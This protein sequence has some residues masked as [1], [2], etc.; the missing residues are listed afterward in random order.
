MPELNRRRFLQAASAAGLAPLIPALPVQAATVSRSASTAQMLWASIY[1]R[2]GTAQNAVGVAQS[3]GVQG[4]AAQGVYARAIQSG[5][6]AAHGATRIGRLAS[7]RSVPGRI[8][9]PRQAPNP[10][11]MRLDLERLIRTDDDDVR[12]P[13]EVDDID[14]RPPKTP[15]ETSQ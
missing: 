2:A 1:A 6:M 3:L 5:A 13:V 11:S 4:A 9:S 7:A 15:T 14:D 8:P 10:R 12:D